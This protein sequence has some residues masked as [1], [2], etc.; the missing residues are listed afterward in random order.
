M[1]RFFRKIRYDLVEKNKTG[2]PALPTRRAGR[3]FKYAIGEI[4]LV[5]I[6]ILI[7]LQINNWNETNKLIAQESNSLKN[8]KIEL[9]MTLLELKADKAEQHDFL[10]AT[11]NVYQ[12]IKQK[13][14]LV[15]SMYRDFYKI[16][17]FNYSFP[18][19]STYETLKAGKFQIIRSDSL[20]NM[21]TN[22][23]ERGYQRLIRK[24][25][26]RRNASRMLFPYYQKH[27]TT[28]M[29]L[30]ENTFEWENIKP[31]IGI[32]NDYEFVI[33]DP[34]FE[35]LIA[36]AIEGRKMFILDYTITIKFIENC[37]DGIDTYLSQISQ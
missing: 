3:Y 27:F 18:K 15:D 6:G 22:V 35:T 11:T 10:A 23:Y 4:V 33:N 34:E 9:A 29:P 5:V 25:D 36:E 13:P 19:T 37:I 16:T 14:S 31:K 2:K 20:R 1:I 17:M 30:V 32:P 8:L 12:Y 28:K 24:V 26:T 21:I 7:A